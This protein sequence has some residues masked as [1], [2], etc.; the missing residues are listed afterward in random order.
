MKKEI[1]KIACDFQDFL[2]VLCAD[3]QNQSWWIWKLI[4]KSRL[5]FFLTNAIESIKKSSLL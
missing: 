3:W 1:K 5:F 2:K 4:D